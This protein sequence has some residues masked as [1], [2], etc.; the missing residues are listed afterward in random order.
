[1][2]KFV[3]GHGPNVPIFDLNFRKLK[4]FLWLM[5]DDGGYDSPNPS[6][7]DRTAQEEPD[8]GV[9][10]NSA[11]GA[12]GDSAPEEKENPSPDLKALEVE[13]TSPKVSY[14]DVIVDGSSRSEEYPEFVVKDAVAEVEVP[15]SLMEEAEPLW[16]SF[17]VGYFMN[18]A[19]HI[20][21][22]HATVN[23][24]WASPLKK[25]KIDVQFIGKTTVLFRI[26]DA[27]I[28]NRILKRKF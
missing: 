8:L 17:I 21:S 16:T 7:Q 25:T 10:Q 5:T 1:M 27:G 15:M 24:I 26:E 11:G 4:R 22:I 19:P 3:I 20:G 13:G 23:R 28:R 6:D 18:D 14:S 9:R 12:G 2:C